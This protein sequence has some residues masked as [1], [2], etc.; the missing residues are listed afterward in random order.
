VLHDPTSERANDRA[1]NAAK[2]RR[3]NLQGFSP[4]ERTI[5]QGIIDPVLQR[6]K[7]LPMKNAG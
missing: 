6:A 7:G 4:F 5:P 3:N 1:T 2:H